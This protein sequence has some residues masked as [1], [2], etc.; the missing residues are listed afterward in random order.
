MRQAAEKTQ[1]MSEPHITNKICRC[2]NCQM[3]DCLWG[4]PLLNAWEADFVGNLSGYGWI[5]NYTEKQIAKLRQIW[6]KILRLR[7]IK[8][9]VRS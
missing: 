6:R 1:K 9:S 2:E 4:D 3:I 8:C 7:K 5:A